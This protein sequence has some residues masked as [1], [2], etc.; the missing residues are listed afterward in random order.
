MG[1]S[2]KDFIALADTIRNFNSLK[3]EGCETANSFDTQQLTVLA[4][5][6]SENYPAFNRGRWL[7]YIAG[8][9]GPNG[10]TR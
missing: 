7:D 10:G 8:K 6:F 9:C 1:M 4:A 2:K 3:D 5:H